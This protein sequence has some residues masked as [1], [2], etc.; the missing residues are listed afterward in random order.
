MGGSY[1]GNA[2]IFIVKT[3]F[4]LY[5]LIVMLRFILQIVR[6]DFYN[7]VSQFIVKATTP[8]L[9]PLRRL[10][11]GIGGVDVAS[12]VLMFAIKMLE[13][14]IVGILIGHFFDIAGLVVRCISDLLDLAVDVFFFS[15]LIQI[16]I[17]WV[18]PGAHNP[19]VSLLHSLNEPILRPARRL[20]PPMHGFDLSPILAIIAL[21]LMTF[22]V[23]Y[24]LR[25]VARAIDP[26]FTYLP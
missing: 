18:N 9:K 8:P 23:V 10:I 24:P 1:L 6:A 12:I 11:P 4:G 5:L 13:I 7:P 16:I 3:V 20:L 17:S 14:F 2:G 25:D 15:I 21:K 19:V 26:T 22:L